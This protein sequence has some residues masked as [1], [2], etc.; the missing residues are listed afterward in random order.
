MF[1]WYSDAIIGG[2]AESFC[3]FAC[4]RTGDNFKKRKRITQID[5]TNHFA[6]N[7][8]VLIKNNDKGFIIKS[9][10]SFLTLTKRLAALFIFSAIYIVYQTIIIVKCAA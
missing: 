2:A 6:L 10:I 3:I 4:D 5:L 1:C 8:M 9:E 7:M